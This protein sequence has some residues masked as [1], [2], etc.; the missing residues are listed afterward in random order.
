MLVGVQGGFLS[1]PSF[2]QIKRFVEWNGENFE[3]VLVVLVIVGLMLSSWHDSRV[4][5]MVVEQPQR[6]DF[7]FVDY[8]AI[9]GNSDAKYRY[10]PMRVMEVKE[11]SLVFKVGNVG[12]TKKLSPTKH[13]KSDRAMHKYYYRKDTLELNLK[14]IAELFE[15]DAIYAAVRPRNIYINGWVVMKLS[16]L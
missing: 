3:W 10:I 9:D 4:T 7:F 6:N 15:S 13:V 11:N 8:L 5:K 1:L 12:Q 14:Q 16:E 2:S